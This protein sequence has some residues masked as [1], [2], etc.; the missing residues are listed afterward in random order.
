M[1]QVI[2]FHRPSDVVLGKKFQHVINAYEPAFFREIKYLS[3]SKGT[4]REG[5]ICQWL[6][7]SSLAHFQVLTHPIWWG[8]REQDPN[9][10]LQQWLKEKFLS[11]DDTLHQEAEP[12]R[13][14]IFETWNF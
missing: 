6:Q 14:K 10:H 1:Q 12:Y 4:W 11:L 3:D 8:E 7:D 2:S 13:Q 5:C 9:L